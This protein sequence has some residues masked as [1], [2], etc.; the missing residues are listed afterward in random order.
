[1]ADEV[2]DF[3]DDVPSGQDTT[4]SGADTQTGGEQTQAGESTVVAAEETLAGADTQLGES[5]EPGAGEDSLPAD[6]NTAKMVPLGTAL[7][8]RD[9][10][11]AAEKALKDKDKPADNV[12]FTPP[13]PVNN[14]REYATYNE[15]VLE[16]NIM[17][18]RMNTSE[19]F[20][21]KEHGAELVDKAREWALARMDAD[22]TFA[23]SVMENADP[24]DI[25][26]AAYK[27]HVEFEAWK[28]SKK[29]APATLEVP[30]AKVSEE[31][32]PAV[33]MVAAVKPKPDVKPAP[34]S[35]VNATSAGGNHTIP[36]GE[37][38]AF[39]SVFPAP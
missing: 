2:L 36:A 3:L 37:G 34:R 22:P 20:A 32:K 25:A 13:D 35:I 7:N 6:D 38:Q 23:K 4:T 24:Y 16:L 11:V 5:T 17:N 39:D 27:E 9:R 29:V 30:A 10:M 21:R 26:V 31:V 8:W 33:A 1:M 14:P 28:A 15:R 19:R 12:E 18:E